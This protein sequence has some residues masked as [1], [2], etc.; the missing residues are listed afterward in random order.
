MF[1]AVDENSPSS[2]LSKKIKSQAEA[3]GAESGSLWLLMASRKTGVFLYRFERTTN[4]LILEEHT[5]GE[6]E[7]SLW[8]RYEYYAKTVSSVFNRVCREK[9]IEIV[10]CRR[11]PMIPCLIQMFKKAKKSYGFFL[12]Y[13]IPTFP[14]LKEHIIARQWRVLASEIIFSKALNALVD[15]FFLITDTASERK[16]P[17]KNWTRISNGINV[18]R[19][20]VRSAL[21]PI[22]D[23]LHLLGLANVAFWHG[24]D[25]VIKGL[26]DYYSD[27]NNKFP[28]FFHIAGE[29][30][31][32][33][34]L[35]Q[36]ALDLAVEKYVIFHGP[37]YGEELDKLINSC[38]IAVASLGLHRIGLQE[39]SVLKAREYCARGMPFFMSMK[40]PDFEEGLRFISYV[41]QDDSA[42]NMN[43]VVHFSRAMIENGDAVIKEM[44]AY[45]ELHLDWKKTMNKVYS[46]FAELEEKK[47]KPFPEN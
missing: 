36:M 34:S 37:V 23:G 27:A 21:R 30:P 40:D 26:S 29:G 32:L 15:H 18:D 43:D 45:A 46:V 16:I 42:V 3:L 22:H 17:F 9:S 44:R 8:K 39:G 12:G 2:G 20:P 31:V 19:I 6:K 41:P 14:F 38:N 28:I 47:K 1:F 13:E 25:R 4:Q 35:K 10:Y 11:I 5:Y 33:Y 24:Y 7:R